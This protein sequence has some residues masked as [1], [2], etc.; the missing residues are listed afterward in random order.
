MIKWNFYWLFHHSQNCLLIQINSFKWHYLI[1]GVFS[2]L[3][4]VFSLRSLGTRALDPPSVFV[5]RLRCAVFGA[6]KM[7]ILQFSNDFNFVQPPVWDQRR[8]KQNVSSRYGQKDRI[9]I[10]RRQGDRVINAVRNFCKSKV[11]FL[12]SG[13]VARQNH[14]RSRGTSWHY[15][16]VL[17]ASS[18]YVGREC[19]WSGETVCYDCC[20]DRFNS[21][22]E[23][24]WMLASRYTTSSP[25]FFLVRQ[26]R[27]ERTSQSKIRTRKN[28]GLPV[29]LSHKAFCAR[30]FK[31]FQISNA[32]SY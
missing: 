10:L 2:P 17:S 20:F 1:S 22:F 21:V 32:H 14:E 30:N 15:N 3:L 16:P 25:T 6:S 9:Q 5:A 18:S 26:A 29:V 27:R 13:L 23:N 28:M 24:G 8:Y 19:N 4:F 7:F 12:F 11:T 31:H